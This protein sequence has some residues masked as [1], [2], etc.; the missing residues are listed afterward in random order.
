MC[1]EGI[2][3]R[4][5]VMWV[6]RETC[7]WEHWDTR[8]YACLWVKVHFTPILMST[9]THTAFCAQL[10]CPC[11]LLT[12]YINFYNIKLCMT[13]SLLAAHL[14]NHHKSET[15]CSMRPLIDDYQV[16]YLILVSACMR[17]FWS[18]GKKKWHRCIHKPWSFLAARQ[19]SKVLLIPLFQ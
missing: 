16:D 11:A 17:F 1:C 18:W 8:I 19:F 9:L 13:S 2:C 4:G 6:C 7:I 3:E 15:K 5:A 12:I 10:S 14:G